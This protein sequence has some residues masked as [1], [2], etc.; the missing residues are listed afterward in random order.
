MTLFLDNVVKDLVD[1][2]KTNLAG[3]MWENTVLLFLADNGGW[4]TV[5]T[6][7]ARMRTRSCLHLVRYCMLS[8]NW[9]RKRLPQKHYTKADACTR[10]CFLY[11][12][13]YVS[14]R[15]TAS[16]PHSPA[17]ARTHART[18]TR[19]YARTHEPS[20]ISNRPGILSW[21]RLKLSTAWGL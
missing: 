21:C 17:C 13:T 20:L 16:S 5:L 3:D 1:G 12:Y 14:M 11:V 2:V 15:Y 6:L 18:H 8:H 4:C 9:R 10:A 7:H 19:M